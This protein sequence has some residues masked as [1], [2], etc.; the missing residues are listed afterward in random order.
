MSAPYA[1]STTWHCYGCSDRP[2]RGFT[3]ARDAIALGRARAHSLWV[4]LSDEHQRDGYA[5]RPMPW[6]GPG[7][8][9]HVSYDDGRAGFVRV[10]VDDGRPLPI[11]PAESR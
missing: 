7:E 8:Y 3:E 1:T 9:Q 6:E 11:S 2:A 10:P 5:L 4:L